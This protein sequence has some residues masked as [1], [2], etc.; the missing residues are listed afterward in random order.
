MEPA[1]AGV[2]H[3][4]DNFTEGAEVAVDVVVID[5]VLPVVPVGRR[6]AG[7]EPETG[8]AEAGD[9]VGTAVK[10][11]EVA[12]TVTVAL[13]VDA[14]IDP[15]D[16]GLPVPFRAARLPCRASPFSAPPP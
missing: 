10:L 12:V 2:A 13:Q 14:N 5:D 4:G 9:M 8:D 15:A 11:R 6:E 3:E 16:D 1:T 7:Q